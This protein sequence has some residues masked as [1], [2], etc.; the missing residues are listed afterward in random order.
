MR[1]TASPL[2]EVGGYGYAQ[3][4]GESRSE[5]VANPAFL[6][7]LLYDNHLTATDY[8]RNAARDP[9]RRGIG[10]HVDMDALPIIFRVV[11]DNEGGRRRMVARVPA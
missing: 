1:G 6:P 5:N 2:F 4:Y 9:G 8:K 10:I 7:F 11:E 3:L